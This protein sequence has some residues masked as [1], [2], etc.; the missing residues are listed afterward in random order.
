MTDR[1]AQTLSAGRPASPPQSSPVH[2]A[3]RKT[4]TGQDW[5]RRTHGR[6]QM[7]R[8]FT[9]AENKFTT[10]LDIWR[11]NIKKLGKCL[12]LKLIHHSL[13]IRWSAETW[14]VGAKL[15]QLGHSQKLCRLDLTERQRK[16]WRERT[17][18]MKMLLQENNRPAITAKFIFQNPTTNQCHQNYPCMVFFFCFFFFIMFYI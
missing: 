5:G 4:K 12:R 13:N 7:L 8:I 14:R 11:K 17:D 6:K 10:Y 1:L 2:S 9:A 16:E 18:Q 3:A 15:S